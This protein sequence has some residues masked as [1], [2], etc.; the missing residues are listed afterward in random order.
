MKLLH[1]HVAAGWP[2]TYL[3]LYTRR[4]GHAKVGPQRP[5]RARPVVMAGKDARA[6]LTKPR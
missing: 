6:Q 5:L 2:T 1:V 4:R 3:V